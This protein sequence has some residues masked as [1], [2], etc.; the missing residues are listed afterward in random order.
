[1]RAPRLFAAALLALSLLIGGCGFQL[2]GAQ[3]L[4]F[5]TLYLAI[6]ENSEL[7]ADLRR[8][9]KATGRTQLVDKR[10]EAEAVFSTLLDFRER[11]V[12][13]YNSAGR[14]REIQLRYRYTY[15]VQNA[16]GE[17]LGQPGEVILT[18]DVTY[19]DSQLLSK[20]AEEEL[21][22]Q[23]MQRDLVQQLL[24]RLAAIKMTAVATE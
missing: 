5:R 7:G 1:M 8:Q 9:I 22:W 3:P 13:S 24:R 20:A 16:K 6:P 12:L 14:V 15:R 10:E 18:R 4:P 11:L 17:N 21:L 19:D 23:D 2:R